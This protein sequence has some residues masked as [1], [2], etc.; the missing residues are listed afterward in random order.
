MVPPSASTPI[1]RRRQRVWL[2]VATV[3]LILGGRPYAWLP[4]SLEALVPAVL[5]LVGT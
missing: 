2:A 3:L 4:E 5:L 1:D